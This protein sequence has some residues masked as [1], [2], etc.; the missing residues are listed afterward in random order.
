[1]Q[2]RSD[3]AWRA[4]RPDPWYPFHPGVLVGFPCPSSLRAPLQGRGAGCPSDV[5]PLLRRQVAATAWGER[6]ALKPSAQTGRRPPDRRARIVQM[7][8]VWTE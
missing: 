4:G 3:V 5:V 2:M 1:M 6:T 7:M 8:W